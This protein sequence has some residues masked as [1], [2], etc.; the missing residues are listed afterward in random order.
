MSKELIEKLEKIY[1]E[2]ESEKSI[3]HLSLLLA[4][5]DSAIADS[6]AKEGEEKAKA[7][8]GYMLKI[9]D[10][11]SSAILNDKLKTEFLVKAVD[12]ILEDAK[13]EEPEV[14]TEKNKKRK[15]LPNPERA[16]REYIGERPRDVLADRRK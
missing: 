10:Y 9:R 7:L 12:A 1:D 6:C 15:K 5:V 3:Q 13:P 8:V 2:P 11:V 16:G 4:F 14:L